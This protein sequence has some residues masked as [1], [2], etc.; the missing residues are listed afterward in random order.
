MKVL[1]V[2]DS[3]GLYGAET[4]LL[5]LAEEQRAQ[6]FDPVIGSIGEPAGHP[7]AIEQEAQRRGLAVQRFIMPAGYSR[8]GARQI[9][10][11]VRSAR[12]DIVHTHGY[13]GDV[14]LGLVPAARRPAPVI[15]TVHGYASAGWFTRNTLYE[16]ADAVSLL[17]MD[18]VIAV[19]TALAKNWRL[20]WVPERRL[21]VIPNGIAEP[22]DVEDTGH[23]DSVD[24]RW[25][26]VEEFC[27]SG[28]VIGSVG[29]LA[30][31]K[32]HHVLLEAA[33]ELRQRGLEAKVLLLGEGPQR[34]FLEQRARELGL[35]DA[36]CMPGFCADP[37]RFL[38]RMSVFALPSLTEGLPLALL[39]AMRARV[40][41]VASQVGG[42]PEVLDHGGC[43]VLIERASAQA[44][45]GAV[46]RLMANPAERQAFV[47]RATAR[48]LECYR[49]SAMARAYGA[50]YERIGSSR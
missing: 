5:T 45:A 33:H 16:L 10:E 11:F 18:H 21:S 25:R 12:V 34:G 26:A 37:R 24:A 2:I 15:A 14:L 23:V 22:S 27:A 47:E 41:I 42:I 29:R 19:S 46:E 38:S 13:K 1:H 36:L 40:P 7:K 49:S 6:G 32:A 43:G 4:V 9:F 39:E 35:A 28:I 44:L 3:A 31:V 8:G 50:L 48:F 20:R 17:G 30:I